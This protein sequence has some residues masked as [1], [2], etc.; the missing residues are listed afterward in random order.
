M[1]AYRKTRRRFVSPWPGVVTEPATLVNIEASVADQDA[2]LRIAVVVAV[3]MTAE[4]Q[5]DVGVVSVV[6]T[7]IPVAEAAGEAAVGV[8]ILLDGVG[9]VVDSEHCSACA[10]VTTRDT[11]D[12]NAVHQ[13][14]LQ[15]AK[16]LLYRD[17]IGVRQR[18]RC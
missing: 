13:R 2:V 1:G 4:R 18:C 12:D 11:T 5:A 14:T 9:M 6:E 7:E 16:Q 3:P 8:E 10:I 17:R 15:P